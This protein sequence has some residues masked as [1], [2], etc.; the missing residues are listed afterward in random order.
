M[1]ILAAGV[2]TSLCGADEPD[3]TPDGKVGEAGLVSPEASLAT[4]PLTI[5]MMNGLHGLVDL[6]LTYCFGGFAGRN[7]DHL[8]GE[9]L[10]CT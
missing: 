3:F 1:L 9:T 7:Y 6:G 2:D 10:R 5:A 4:S 8:N